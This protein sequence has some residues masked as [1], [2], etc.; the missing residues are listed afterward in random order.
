RAVEF[1]EELDILPRI[2]FCSKCQ[3]PMRK[4]KD[5]SR[6]DKQKWTCTSR[7]ACGHATTI[8]TET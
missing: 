7:T 5:N 4:T 8:R 2:R 1:F 6:G 3:N